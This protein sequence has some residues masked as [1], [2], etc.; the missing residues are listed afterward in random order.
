LLAHLPIVVSLGHAFQNPRNQASPLFLPL[1]RSSPPTN[2]SKIQLCSWH[3]TSPIFAADY[4]PWSAAQLRKVLPFPNASGSG[5]SSNN[6]GFGGSSSGLEIPGL[7]GTPSRKQQQHQDSD[8]AGT[9]TPVAS[10]SSTSNVIGE[11]TPTA[12][13][14]SSIPGLEATPTQ[15]STGGFNASAARVYR[16]A[17]A[18]ADSCVRVSPARRPCQSN[19]RV[20]TIAYEH[21]AHARSGPSIPT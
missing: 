12:V 5:S 17:T 8:Q 6:L 1:T 9:L 4:Q 13:R 14:T 7:P 21:R 3:G 19:G 18:G 20:L 11:T 16:L 10:S 2:R 15:A